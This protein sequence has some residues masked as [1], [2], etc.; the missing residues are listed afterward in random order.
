VPVLPS[1]RS[2]IARGRWRPLPARPA[3]RSTAVI[4]VNAITW[5]LGEN[6]SIDGGM[7]VIRCRSSPSHS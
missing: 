3:A 2:N 7:T 4:V 5:F 1:R 6:A